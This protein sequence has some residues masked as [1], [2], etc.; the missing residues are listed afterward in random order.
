MVDALCLYYVASEVTPGNGARMCESLPGNT[1]WLLCVVVVL[2]MSTD[3]CCAELIV[4]EATPCPIK[5]SPQD[6]KTFCYSQE[7][8]F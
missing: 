1:T 5:L 7:V 4:E 3:V 6:L 2:I 8:L